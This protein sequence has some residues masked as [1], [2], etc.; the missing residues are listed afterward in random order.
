MDKC[1]YCNWEKGQGHDPLCPMSV[2]GGERERR[3]KLYNQ[4]LQKGRL[5]RGSG[6]ESLV[7][8]KPT[9]FAMGYD[10]GLFGE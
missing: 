4:G 2:E 10:D 7:F 1:K 9:T 6:G 5:D 3:I 8:K